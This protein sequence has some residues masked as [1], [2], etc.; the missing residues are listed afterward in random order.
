MKRLNL[1]AL[2]LA[3]AMIAAFSVV[4][5]AADQD[6]PPQ[7]PVPAEAPAAG[8]K[9]MD[10]KG[11]G[12]MGMGQ[13][14]VAK[15]PKGQVVA[16]SQPNPLQLLARLSGKP[17]VAIKMLVMKKGILGAAKELRVA[18]KLVTIIVERRFK[19]IDTMVIN[20]RLGIKEAIV[21][22]MEFLRRVMSLFSG[23]EAGQ[24]MGN[25]AMMGQGGMA[26]M[27][28]QGMDCKGMMGQGMGAG[29]N[30]ETSEKC[31]DCEA[32]AQET[33]VPAAPVVT[34]PEVPAGHQH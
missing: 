11:M 2:V 30:M 7:A 21:L 18:D 20:G 31:Q 8:L 15:A 17:L 19:L 14:P 26:G 27:M 16:D 32:A 34:T 29:M 22:K 9:L 24:G 10:Q 6:A 5:I 28:D 12:Q 3:I 4:A 1:L 23:K 33:A 25:G 13:M